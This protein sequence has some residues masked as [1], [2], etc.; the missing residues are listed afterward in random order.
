MWLD[1]WAQ[2]AKFVPQPLGSR[3]PVAGPGHLIGVIYT[4]GTIGK[5]KGVMSTAQSIATMTAI[6]LVE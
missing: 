6:Q 2:V 3:V 5:P 4:G 1:L